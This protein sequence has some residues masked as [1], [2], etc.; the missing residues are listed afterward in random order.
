ML[1]DYC[2]KLGDCV[3]RRLT[4]RLAGLEMQP[5][6]MN[7]YAVASAVASG[8]FFFSH[9][10]L[11]ALLCLFFHGIFDYMDGG[12]S[13]QFTSFASFFFLQSPLLLLSM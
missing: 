4:L 6:M 1:G 10:T 8:Y 7:L 12:I 2:R 5:W 13:R 11:L 9:N 3:C